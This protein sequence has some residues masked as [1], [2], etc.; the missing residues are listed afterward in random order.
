MTAVHVRAEAAINTR[1]GL[2][3][4]FVDFAKSLNRIDAASVRRVFLKSCNSAVTARRSI[5]CSFPLASS[6]SSPILVF[7]SHFNPLSDTPD[8]NGSP[9]PPPG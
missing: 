3:L 7:G 6:G 9:N 5:L 2:T 8:A 4:D 1:N